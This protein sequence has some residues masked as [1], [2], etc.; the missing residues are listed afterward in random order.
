MKKPK[1][2]TLPLR[3]ITEIHGALRSYAIRL[4]RDDKHERAREIEAHGDE[5]LLAMLYMTDEPEK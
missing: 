1:N 3:D 2:L 5:L 4:R